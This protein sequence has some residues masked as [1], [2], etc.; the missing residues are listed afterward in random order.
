MERKQIAPVRSIPPESLRQTAA[1]RPMNAPCATNSLGQ[2]AQRIFRNQAVRRFLQAKLTVNQLG[3]VY[4]REAAEVAAQM[5]PMPATS[6]SR[7]QRTC[8]CGGVAGPEGECEACRTKRL[9]LQRMATNQAPTNLAPPIIQDVLAT[10]GQPLDAAARAFFEPRFGYDFSQ[11]R[12]HRGAKAA[13]S[14]AAVN[15]LAYTV[16]RNVVFG[17]HQ[18]APTTPA[19]RQL[20]AHELVH[21]IQQGTGG[22]LPSSI[23]NPLAGLHQPQPQSIARQASPPAPPAAP[24]YG[25]ACSS[26]ASDPCQI[27]RCLPAEI[28]TIRDDLSRG[29]RYV[30]RATSALN[31]SPRTTDTTRALDWYFNDHSDGTA[32]TVRTRLECILNCLQETQTNHRFG[33]HPDHT[34]LAYVCVGSTPICSQALTDVCFTSQHFSEGPHVR[35]EVAIHECAHRMGMSLGAPASVPDIYRLILR[36][37][38]L[39]TNEAIQNA[40]SYALFAGAIVEG[41]PLTLP[42]TFGLSGGVAVPEQGAAT[43]QARLYLGTEFQHPV[44][45][46]FNPTLG[47]GL[48]LTGNP[49][50][51][52]ATGIPPNPTLLTSLV[53][54]IRLTDPRPGSAGGG[55]F[56]LSGGPALAISG[57][58]TRVG[59]EAGVAVG[60][61]WQW[62]DLSAGIGYAYDPTRQAEMQNMFTAS[63]GLTFIPTLIR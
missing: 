46:I 47:I 19:G 15:A 44:L 30:N 18:Y 16:G 40:D 57:T 6:T 37:L 31:A 23:G 43:W 45:G 24:T 35:A 28:S 25:R 60:Y 33:C 29:I 8:A 1:T 39:D 2:T 54:G 56:S 34:A 3:D 20:L 17:A 63:F 48:G 10:P 7:L 32:T 11:V 36:F 50:T 52:S 62:L 21:T 53:G 55:Y 27:T 49:V 58:D 26:G 38:N 12:V 41:V 13:A 5:T 42:L 4:E 61:R 9:S 51:P 14:A 59:A 22:A